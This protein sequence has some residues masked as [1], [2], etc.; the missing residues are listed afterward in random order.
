[1]EFRSTFGLDDYDEVKWVLLPNY[2]LAHILVATILI[3]GIVLR[4]YVIGIIGAVIMETLVIFSIKKNFKITYS[5]IKEQ[6]NGRKK[7]SYNYTFNDN[8][9]TS[10][11]NNTNGKLVIKYSDIKK[12][13]HKEKYTII[14]T[15]AH[16]FFIL[17]SKHFEK[18]EL[19]EFLLSKNQKIKI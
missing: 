19:M 2:I 16:T 3:M 13:K 5:R 4:E 18:N 11:C 6:I 9:F 1:M 7:L 10:I 8:S 17:D 14:F 15:K 12:I